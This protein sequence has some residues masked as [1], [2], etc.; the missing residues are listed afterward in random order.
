MKKWILSA[1]EPNLK[2]V[3]KRESL[4]TQGNGY[5]GIRAAFEEDYPLSVRDTL[6]NGVFDRPADEVSELANIPD[7]IN[8]EFEINGERFS[9]LAG[10]ISEYDA[11]L[12]MKTGEFKRNLIWAS[13][14]GASV[15]ISFSR[16]ISDSR[17]HIVAQKISVTSLSDNINLKIKTGINGKVTNEGVQH[18][19]NPQKRAYNDGIYGMHLNTLESNVC[20]A[21]HYTLKT[22]IDCSK[23]TTIDRRSIYTLAELKL[24]KNEAF[25]CEKITS[26]TTARDFEYLDKQASADQLISDGK[27]YLKDASNL[28]YDALLAESAASWNDFWASSALE[29]KSNNDFIDQA[30]LFAQ[31][32]LH[33]MASRDDNRLGIGAKALSGEGY[34]GHSFWDTEIFILPYY[35]VTNPPAA[36]RLLEYRY[37]LLNVSKE[38]AKKHGYIGAMYPWESTWITE[39]EACLEYGALDLVT[40]ERRQF[41]MGTDEI[42][43]TAG[44]AY[45][46][47]QYYCIT[48]DNEFME[49]YGNE[50]IVMTALFWATRA[51]ERNGRYKILNVIG[52][53]EYKENVNNNAYTN[54]MAHKNLELAKNI[55]QN[56]P[57][58]LHDKLSLEYDVEHI[59]ALICD[60]ADNMYLPQAD[61]DGIIS[62]FEGCKDLKEIDITYYKELET[63]FDIFNDY[64]F[65]EIQKMQ[66]YK[67]ADLVML[68]Y[69]MQDRFDKELTRKN[70]EYY[71]KRT[72]HD[73]S[74]SLCIHALVASHLGMQEF[75]DKLYFDSLCVDLGDNTNNSDAGIH[76]A[77]IG[78][79]WLDTVMGYGGLHF[80]E[81]G[82]FIDPVLPDGWSEYSYYCFYKGTKFKVFVNINGCEV[83]RISGNKVNI[84]VNGKEWS[85]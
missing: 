42:H 48:D 19:D 81:N 33:I 40:G 75:A 20:V 6:I 1:H 70:F 11:S 49:K 12:N 38:K 39:G 18:F 51:E 59:K 64:G 44:V 60:V 22:N 74:L 13:P 23:T 21:I 82:L 45:G 56:C 8:F 14:K 55:L 66:A 54:Y 31:Y 67:Q 29:V 7:A 34:M 16:I 26:Y 17:K 28:G 52:A 79:I 35:L 24:E 25:E 71:E 84:Y 41:T 57:K 85:E 36:R 83:K 63:V 50:I 43:I 9:M 68:F 37:H 72:L 27:E 69:L 10:K 3:R 47:W 65:N 46:V 30:V 58:A 80:N 61:S 53:D 32:H 76:S 15:R 4:W 77:S 78:G 2:G 73:S 5:M 62:Q